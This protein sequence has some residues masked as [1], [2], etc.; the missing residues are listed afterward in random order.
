MECNK[1]KKL[2]F[3]DVKQYFK[4][5]GCELLEKEYKN[6]NTPMKYRCDCGNDECKIRFSKFKSGQRCRKCGIKKNIWEKQLQL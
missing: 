3:E 4:D 2:T 5:R 1:S 6:C